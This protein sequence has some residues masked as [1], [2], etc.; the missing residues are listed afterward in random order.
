MGLNQA[1]LERLDHQAESDRDRE[2]AHRTILMFDFDE[3]RCDNS[4][5][6]HLP[7]IAR[8]C[9]RL[10]GADAASKIDLASRPAPQR[11]V[12]AVLDERGRGLL[13]HHDKL[14]QGRP[15]DEGEFLDVFWSTVGLPDA[16]AVC[17]EFG[18]YFLGGGYD[19]Y[20]TPTV[21]VSSN[22]TEEG[23]TAAVREFEESMLA[24]G[25]TPMK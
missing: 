23:H 4:F 9:E 6:S 7:V 14:V 11:T 10:A 13:F 17:Y 5:E 3:A 20:L 16:F 24:L 22:L 25:F 19:V 12:W 8:L 21:N 1:E 2:Y 15:K 18:R